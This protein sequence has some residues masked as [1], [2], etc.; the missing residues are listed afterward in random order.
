MT[1]AIL[2]N[3]Q[4]KVQYQNYKELLIELHKI[5]EFINIIEP[6]KLFSISMKLISHEGIIPRSLLNFLE[7]Q[8]YVLFNIQ[9][10]NDS[11]LQQK[12]SQIYLQN[13]KKWYSNQLH[14]QKSQPFYSLKKLT[15]PVSSL[16]LYYLPTKAHHIE[17]TSLIQWVPQIT[18]Q[19]FISI[20][21]SS[22]TTYEKQVS[23]FLQTYENLYPFD[24][25]LSYVKD[26]FAPIM[27]I[28]F[29]NMGHEGL[30]YLM[31]QLKKLDK[32]Q[33]SHLYLVMFKKEQE[34][35]ILQLAHPQSEYFLNTIST[36][37]KNLFHHWLDWY[38]LHT[39]QTL[40]FIDSI[41]ILQDFWKSFQNMD[42][43]VPTHLQ[44]KVADYPQLIS[45]MT[46]LIE[47]TEPKWKKIQFKLIF[48]LDWQQKERIFALQKQGY[49]WISKE[50][51]DNSHT[52]HLAYQ[53]LARYL[54]DEYDAYFESIQKMMR[55]YRLLANWIACLACLKPSLNNQDLETM[56]QWFAEHSKQE[57]LL[58]IIQRLSQ[59]HLI[60]SFTLINLQ[61]NPQ[62]YNLIELYALCSD[63]NPN[64]VIQTWPK[65]MDF[66]QKRLNPPEFDISK[67]QKQSFN[68]MIMICILQL[69]S[70]DLNPVQLL[71]HFSS[72]N[73]L[74]Q[75]KLIQI[76]L[77]MEKGP[78]I[79]YEKIMS[80]L[81][82]TELGLHP[83]KVF[84]T[85]FPE[86]QFLYFKKTSQW[87][88]V[89]DEMKQML[90]SLHQLLEKFSNPQIKIFSFMSVQYSFKDFIQE[91]LISELLQIQV[92]LNEIQNL[93]SQ[94]EETQNS[95]IFNSL[96]IQ[97]TSL[98]AFIAQLLQKKLNSHLNYHRLL[99]TLDSSLV[100]ENANFQ[101]LFHVME[102]NFSKL[103]TFNMEKLFNQDIL[104]LLGEYKHQQNILER[105]INLRLLDRILLPII[106]KFEISTQKQLV[107]FLGKFQLASEAIEHFFERIKVIEYIH[108]SWPKFTEQLV[109]RHISPQNIWSICE[110]HQFIDAKP[111]ANTHW[112]ICFCFIEAFLEY[113]NLA[114]ILEKILK[115]KKV[116]P[117][118]LNFN[119]EVDHPHWHGLVRQ[120]QDDFKSSIS[121]QASYDLMLEYRI[122]QFLKTGE[123]PAFDAFSQI[124]EKLQI[125][126]RQKLLSLM[127]NQPIDPF[128]NNFFDKVQII[129]KSNQQKSIQLLEKCLLSSDFDTQWHQLVAIFS[130][131]EKNDTFPWLEIIL[132]DENCL[133]QD[134]ILLKTN[135][136]NLSYDWQSS[137]PETEVDN[138]AIINLPIAPAITTSFY[139][140]WFIEQS[141]PPTLSIPKKL[142]VNP[143]TQKA[144]HLWQR[145]LRPCVQ[146]INRWLEMPAS[147]SQL[148]AELEE[149]DKWPHLDNELPLQTWDVHTLKTFINE[150]EFHTDHHRWNPHKKKHLLN[151]L[152]EILYHLAYLPPSLSLLLEKYH[153]TKNQLMQGE[154][155]SI[156]LENEF[157]GIIILLY[158]KSLKKQAYPPQ[159]LCLL[160]ALEYG[161]KNII[162][163]VDTSEG[164][165]LITALLAVLTYARK[166]NNTII[167]RT[168]HDA[169]IIQDFFQKKHHQFFKLLN[170]HCDVLMDMEDIQRFKPGGIYYTTHLKFEIFN[171]LTPA[172]HQQSFDMIA[173]EVDENLDRNQTVAIAQTFT[174]MNDI[175]WFFEDMNEFVDSFFSEEMKCS[176]DKWLKKAFKY[177]LEKN[178]SVE[179]RIKKLREIYQNLNLFKNILLGSVQSIFYMPLENQLFFIQKIST[180][181]GAYYKLIPYEDNKPLFDFQFG[182][183]GLIQ[184][185]AKR[186]E[187]QKK[188]PFIIP[189]ICQKIGYLNPYNY[190][191]ITRF[192]GLSGSNGRVIELNEL[193]KIFEAHSIRISRYKPKRLEKLPNIFTSNA[194]QHIQAIN[195]TIEQYEQPIVVFCETIQD[196]IHLYHQIKNLPGKTV[197]CITG[198][199]SQ[200]EREQ[201]LF[202]PDAKH[203]AGAP[204]CVTIGIYILARGIDY[205]PQHPKGLLAILT[206]LEENERTETQIYG[207]PARAGEL[208]QIIAIYDMQAILK[209][210]KKISILH[211]S[212]ELF[213]YHK[214]LIQKNK[215]KQTIEKRQLQ[216]LRNGCWA[217][218]YEQIRAELMISFPQN[219]EKYTYHLFQLF[220]KEWEKSPLNPQ[221]P[222]E[223]QIEWM[224]SMKDKVNIVFHIEN[225][226]YNQHS[227]DDF[228]SELQLYFHWIQMINPDLQNHHF[229]IKTKEQ[230]SSTSL[231]DI[232]EEKEFNIDYLRLSQLQAPY[233][234][235]WHFQWLDPLGYRWIQCLQEDWK[236]FKKHSNS[237][238]FSYLYE[239][240]LAVKKLREMQKQQGEFRLDYWF[241]F[242]NMLD[243]WLDFEKKLTLILQ[244]RKIQDESVENFLNFQRPLK[245]KL[246]KFF[247]YL[248]PQM[249]NISIFSYF[250]QWFIQSFKQFMSIFNPTAN[251]LYQQLKN[252]I[253]TTHIESN[254]R[255]FITLYH[256]M[257]QV[258]MMVDTIQKLPFWRLDK[259]YW[260]YFFNPIIHQIYDYHL[261][262]SKDHLLL[263]QFK[264]WLDDKS[265]YADFRLKCLGYYLY[266]EQIHQ[267]NYHIYE[268]MGYPESILVKLRDEYLRES[269][270]QFTHYK[271]YEMGR[272][273]KKELQL[274][275]ISSIEKEELTKNT[276]SEEI[277]QH[278]T[279]Y[280]LARFVM[281]KHIQNRSEIHPLCTETH[282]QILE[283]ELV[284]AESN[285][286][287]LCLL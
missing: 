30:F 188:L 219:L 212:R 51:L 239:A 154:T 176:I 87:H 283:N 185:L 10:E 178:R 180:I 221:S 179:S 57:E 142:E 153:Q 205:L 156:Q 60:Q 2:P 215:I 271:L 111:Y 143:V 168:T 122:E 267:H 172:F 274:K 181:N 194:E 77:S 177:I 249:T 66:Y 279:Y 124:F 94:L 136:C 133:I 187:K 14:I 53:Y 191:N 38:G 211:T 42:I 195:Q 85:H 99:Y 101:Q 170:C 33:L 151:R 200:E 285:R 19:H 198:Q 255:N 189:P 89:L 4:P 233:R 190:K 155:H 137:Y 114:H 86:H 50:M 147:S 73:A 92:Q 261:S 134:M 243:A 117:K 22:A 12:F 286:E 149:F 125:D 146:K 259:Y 157:I 6:E 164:K 71:E 248:H 203:H 102:K 173:D 81:H 25:N 96:C 222:K 116:F 145:P 88:L 204:H 74:L 280:E 20:E 27:A 272:F 90:E 175:D 183:D 68:E 35:N 65:F 5:I 16:D 31:N 62:F 160:L 126:A 251:T 29:A 106:P 165:S 9:V 44:V 277:T 13:L 64:L 8:S 61:K 115:A 70:E 182:L 236:L 241:P 43:E 107:R 79:P 266:Q 230:I 24:E 121:Q 199:E 166:E 93:I 67:L 28:L 17:E 41:T 18:T 91:P 167:V 152:Q 229:F 58:N 1:Q 270:T 206:Y 202:N 214:A 80:L 262:L 131:L 184:C 63:K 140:S 15:P 220:E 264:Q 218:L 109:K 84:N 287:F 193:T 39:G 227:T 48:K 217:H 169:L 104:K 59:K 56:A 247:H 128:F 254:K 252:E 257:N 72:L 123:V 208:G 47:M 244:V 240:L 54:D 235:P 207:R 232:H 273:F 161:A 82:D 78:S 284:T 75:K 226:R 83:E 201:W 103:E 119:G 246:D 26:I 162:Y 97:F 163:E 108:T 210:V 245:N 275:L 256:T 34:Q 49:H 113:E 148:I 76:F 281:T 209:K 268:P 263:T 118:K 120:L 141:S 171:A 127:E 258:L 69:I 278:A 197:R 238:N 46:Q 224:I 253:R 225:I 11:E 158:K 52:L 174:K 23:T 242:L 3:Y 55:K 269:S 282:E 186:L 138:Q 231:Q 265:L 234:L 150:I 40:S 192:I 216:Q 98:D 37:P 100:D 132:E 32:D 276:K 135:V 237:E 7:N 95:E 105:I 36:W 223:K 130:W 45:N 112:H 260:L 139:F 144:W 196:S 21:T 213:P 129:L 250:L 228:K 159:I 110:K